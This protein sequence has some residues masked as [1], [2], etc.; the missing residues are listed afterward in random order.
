[1]KVSNKLKKEID[2]LSSDLLEKKVEHIQGEAEATIILA[3]AVI[4]ILVL[5]EE[6]YHG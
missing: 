3:K 4:A 1:M 6:E 5:I 2:S